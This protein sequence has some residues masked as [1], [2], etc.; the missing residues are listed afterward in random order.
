MMVENHVKEKDLF[1]KLMANYSK[2]G[3]PLKNALLPL[4]VTVYGFR[5]TS[6]DFLDE[7]TSTLSL[8]GWFSFVS[9]AIKPQL[10]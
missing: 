8:Q 9:L 10:I 7:M 1:R 3:R 4:I 6:V 5:M 2:S